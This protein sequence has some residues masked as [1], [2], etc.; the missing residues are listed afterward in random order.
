MISGNKRR[1]TLKWFIAGQAGHGKDAFAGFLSEIA[2]ARHVSSSVVATAYVEGFL[3]ERY[4]MTYPSQRECWEDRVNHRERWFEA[5]AAMGEDDPL[6]LTKEILR[7]HD[8]YV[9]I[10]NIREFQAAK[11]AGLV[12]L[13]IWID[14]EERLGKT[15]GDGSLT[16]SASDCH[17]VI[18]NNASLWDL[19][20]EAERIIILARAGGMLRALE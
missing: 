4:G 7:E 19:R 3:R 9:G 13:S 12:A 18:K 8:F 14:A 10:R 16:I 2:G 15:E 11:D 1:E 20:G 6:A 17:L 5:I